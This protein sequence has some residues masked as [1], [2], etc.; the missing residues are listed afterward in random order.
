MISIV[1]RHNYHYVD[2]SDVGLLVTDG[3]IRQV[4]SVSALIWFLPQTLVTLANFGYPV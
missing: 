1:I 4:V 3:I 2:I